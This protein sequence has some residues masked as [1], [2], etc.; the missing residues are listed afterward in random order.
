MTTCTKRAWIARDNKRLV[1][2]GH[3]DAA[4]LFS[5]VGQLR[6]EKDLKRFEN[7]SEFFTGFKD[8]PPAAM[9][10]KTETPKPSPSTV[11]KKKAD[12]KQIS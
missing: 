2:D 5:R 10:A 11:V 8:E 7:A 9:A 4:I 6:H 12:K 3:T 1:G